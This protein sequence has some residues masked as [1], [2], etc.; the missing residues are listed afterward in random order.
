[1]GGYPKTKPAVSR[2]G[3]GC[4]KRKAAL[5]EELSPS[6]PS[7]RRARTGAAGRHSDCPAARSVAASAPADSDTAANCVVAEAPHRGCLRRATPPRCRPTPP[8]ARPDYQAHCRAHPHPPPPP[9]P[10]LSR[11][12]PADG[13]LN[14][15]GTFRVILDD[16]HDDGPIARTSAGDTDRAG[17][18][19]RPGWQDSTNKAVEGTGG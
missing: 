18:L 19:T 8:S 10:A 7:R 4:N 1:M 11:P 13:R 16:R 12:L 17:L 6:P 2:F 15:W 5:V 14:A 9:A 3:A